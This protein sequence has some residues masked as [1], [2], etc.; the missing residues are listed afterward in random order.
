M[1][2]NG[3]CP[4]KNMPKEMFQGG[5]AI[6]FAVEAFMKAKVYD[7]KNEKRPDDN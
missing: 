1:A 6:R 4:D 7:S 2:L 5:L 3:K